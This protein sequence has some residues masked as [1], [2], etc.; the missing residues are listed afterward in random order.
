MGGHP[1]EI[2]VGHTFSRVNL[3]IDCDEKGYYLSLDRSK[4]LRKEEIAK[5]FNVLNKN[6]IP[7]KV[8][9]VDV[10]K[11]AFIGNDYLR[12]VPNKILPFQCSSYFKK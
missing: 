1:F 6:K 3:Y 10:I 5:I 7:V 4:V 2:I 11:N 9:N 12:V 8:Y